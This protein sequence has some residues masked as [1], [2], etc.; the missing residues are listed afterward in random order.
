MTTVETTDT[1]DT[2]IDGLA[3]AALLAVGVGALVLGFLTTINEA[4]TSVHDFLQ[5][6]DGVGPLAGK[7]ILA[8][9][10][11]FGALLVF[12]LIWRGRQLALKPVLIV[13]GVLLLL[14]FLGTFPIFFQAFAE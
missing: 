7:T 4:S 5:F 2:R 8:A 9:L 12:A 10:A 11:Y 13:A 1:Q 14:G 3:A 6:D